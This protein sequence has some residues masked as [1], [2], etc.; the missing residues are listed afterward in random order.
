MFGKCFLTTFFREKNYMNIKNH[1]CIIKKIFR[2]KKSSK[3]INSSKR[4]RREKVTRE[5]VMKDNN[6]RES[7]KREY[8]NKKC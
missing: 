4:M 2:E 1:I 8:G 6:E 7:D 5:K 3:S